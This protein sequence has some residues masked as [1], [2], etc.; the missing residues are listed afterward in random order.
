M[1]MLEMETVDDDEGSHAMATGRLVKRPKM[2]VERPETAAVA[3]M[4]SRLTSGLVSET[5]DIPRRW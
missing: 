4:R 5:D 1:R 2:T 3:V